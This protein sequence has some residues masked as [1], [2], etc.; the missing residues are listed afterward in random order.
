[1]RAILDELAKVARI[2]LGDESLAVLWP[3]ALDS[4][5]PHGALGATLTRWCEADS[6]PLVLLLDEV[7]SL[8]GDTLISVLRQLRGR[9]RGPAQALSSQRRPL[10]RPRRAGTT[11]STRAAERAIITGGKRLQYQGRVFAPS[12]TSLKTGGAFSSDAAHRTRPDRMFTAGGAGDGLE[13][14][15]VGSL[16]SSTRLPTERVPATTKA[17]TGRLPG[18]GG[19]PSWTRRNSSS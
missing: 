3:E 13:A 17:A 10:R 14:D 9:L 12:E 8:V 18:D 4:A 6:R 1:M 2:T 11:A 5:G 7:D 16:G 15:Q 19:E